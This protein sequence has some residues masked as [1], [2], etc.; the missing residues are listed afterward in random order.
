MAKKDLNWL[1]DNIEKTNLVPDID[2]NTVTLIGERCKRGYDIDEHSRADLE[3]DS[4]SSS[5]SYP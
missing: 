1:L 2:E 3:E 4:H 5:E